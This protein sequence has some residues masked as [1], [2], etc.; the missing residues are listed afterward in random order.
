M[1]RRGLI[2]GPCFSGKHTTI[3]KAAEKLIR[4][5]RNDDLVTKVSIGYIKPVR[6]CKKGAIK[7]VATDG[8]LRV[9]VKGDGAVQQFHVYTTRP[10][11]TRQKIEALSA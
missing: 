3:I 11:E 8:G 2:A 6:R 9:T 10:I 4:A 1:T 7:V 5:I